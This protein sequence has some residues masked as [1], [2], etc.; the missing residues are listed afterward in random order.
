MWPHQRY[1][2]ELII[3][4]A[5]TFKQNNN[6]MNGNDVLALLSWTFTQ[7]TQHT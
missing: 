4:S 2:T 5:R 3:I 7:N 1:V 6:N